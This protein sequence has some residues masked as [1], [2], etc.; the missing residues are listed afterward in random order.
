MPF[1]LVRWYVRALGS[2]LCPLGHLFSVGGPVITGAVIPLTQLR[3]RRRLANSSEVLRTRQDQTRPNT[4]H[5]ARKGVLLSGAASTPRGWGDPSSQ[6]AAPGSSASP[7]CF[8]GR[9]SDE[10]PQKAPV[11]FI[12]VSSRAAVRRSLSKASGFN[13]L[14]A[15]YLLLLFH[16]CEAVSEQRA[17][18]CIV[19]TGVRLERGL[20]RG[21]SYLELVYTAYIPNGL[22]YYSALS[23]RR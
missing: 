2:P 14:L 20:P 15:S 18:R 17:A 5:R 13:I 21:V 23:G 22:C 16:Y 1:A 8:S 6:Q 19:A 10:R 9:R 7:L 12:H 4:E 3:R 11:S